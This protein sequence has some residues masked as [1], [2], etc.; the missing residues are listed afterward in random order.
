MISRRS[1]AFVLAAPLTLALAACNDTASGDAATAAAQPIAKVPAPAGTAWR[2]VVTVTEAGGHLVGNPDAP[3]KLVEYGSLTCPACA[4]FSAEAMEPLLE[5]YVNSGRVSFE[6]RNFAVHGPRD[7][8]LA[9]LAR[10]GTKEAVIPL[11]EQVWQ[12]LAAIEGPL[13]ANQAAYEQAM[14]LPMNQRFVAIAQAGGYF[15]FFASRGI[16]A[17][18][19]RA[20]LAD[21]PSLEALAAQTDT[22]G[23]EGGVTGTPTFTLNG[24]KLDGVG[25]WSALEPL[26][27][28][29]GAR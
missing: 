7:I 3:L 27:Q 11:S 19:A 29:A 6:L 28:R 5:K 24:R 16:S 2:D 18:Q 1:L 13:Q 15:D 14:A 23:R 25:N 9:R 22:A 12:N 4:A 26:L 21:L 17:D 20:C 8:V 10:C